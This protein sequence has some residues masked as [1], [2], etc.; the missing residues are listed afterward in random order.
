MIKKIVYIAITV[1]LLAFTAVRLKSNK[2]ATEKRVFQYDKEKPL[3]VQG[4]TV[5]PAAVKNEHSFTGYFEPVKE[6]KVSA[7]IQGKV[8][9]VLVDQGAVVRKGQVLVQL[10][11]SLLKLQLQSVEAQING[12]EADVKR[13]TVLAQADAIEGVQLETAELGLT[14]AKVQ[15]AT[16]EEQIAK[17]TIRAPFSGIVTEKLTEAGAFAAPGMP[18]L[19]ITDITSLRFTLHAPERDLPLFKTGESS[20]VVADAYPDLPLTGKV[21]LV[22]SKSNKA[23]SFPIQFEVKNTPDQKVK[24]GMFGKAVIK[25][26]SGEK[27]IVI[28]A[29]VI[30]GSGD[31][32]R[33]YVVKNEKAVL[34]H[35]TIAKR[36]ENKVVVSEGLNGGDIIVAS[37]FINLFNGANVNLKPSQP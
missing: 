37:G 31:G 27:E 21:I 15:R 1:A 34:Q 2:E 28:P 19:Q 11:N 3:T 5:E 8:N 12:L 32:A 14:T 26:V 29:S 17:T 10:D 36:F 9:A 7:D 35:I 16:I 18:L 23:N 13:Y 33:V 30:V 4:Y 24:A 6:T 22:G 20:P 25:K